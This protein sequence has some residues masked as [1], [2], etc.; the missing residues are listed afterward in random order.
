MK[1]NSIDSIFFSLQALKSNEPFKNLILPHGN[2]IIA[3]ILY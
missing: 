2:Q 1:I 3:V